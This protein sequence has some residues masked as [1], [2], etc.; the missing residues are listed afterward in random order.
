MK[1]EEIIERLHALIE[2]LKSSYIDK[3]QNTA[4]E[5][6][7]DYDGNDEGVEKI[8]QITDEAVKSFQSDLE[9]VL[10]TFEERFKKAQQSTDK[11]LQAAS[12]EAHKSIKTGFATIF[13]EIYARLKGLFNRD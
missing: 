11:N 9:K 10:A 12:E 1:L 13:E 2:E 3:L 8:K 7:A 6:L 5:L 4:E